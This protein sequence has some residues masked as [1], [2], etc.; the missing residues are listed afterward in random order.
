MTIEDTL[1]ALAHSPAHPG[2]EGIEAGVFDRID[3]DTRVRRQGRGLLL[4]AVGVASVAGVAGAA[5]PM[6]QRTQ[7]AALAPIALAP[8]TLLGGG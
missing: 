8:S 6:Q 5:I 1:A 4:A 3:G 7:P 2:L